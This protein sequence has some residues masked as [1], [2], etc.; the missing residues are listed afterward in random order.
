METL[1]TLSLWKHTRA[2]VCRLVMGRR[3]L[4]S[5]FGKYEINRHSINNV[6][7]VNFLKY[8]LLSVSKIC[9]KGNEVK[10]FYEE[11]LLTNCVTKKVVMSA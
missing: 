3:V 2:V 11:C 8:N 7:Y 6:H 4:F 5:K 9:D 10:F 1:N